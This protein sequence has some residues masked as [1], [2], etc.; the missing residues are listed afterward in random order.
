MQIVCI[1]CHCS[2][3][4]SMVEYCSERTH[5]VLFFS[6]GEPSFLCLIIK[7]RLCRA[8]LVQYLFRNFSGFLGDL[9]SILEGLDILDRM[10]E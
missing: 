3:H 5:P 9:D 4:P 1:C 8:G 10:V 2:I 7:L 6:V